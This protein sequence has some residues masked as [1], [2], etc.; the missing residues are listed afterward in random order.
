MSVAASASVAGESGSAVWSM[1]T[2]ELRQRVEPREPGIADHELQQRGVRRD[3][4]AIHLIRHPGIVEEHLVELEQLAAQIAQARAVLFGHQGVRRVRGR[5]GRG[6]RLGRGG[7]KSGEIETLGHHLQRA[8]RVPRPLGA[9]TIPVELEA[10]AVRDRAGRAPR[11]RRGRSPR[12]AECR[13]RAGGGARRRA[14][15][16]RDTGSRSDTARS[17]PGRADRPAG[18]PRCSGRCDG[19]SR[20]RSERP[21]SDPCAASPRTRARPNR[22]PARVRD[23]T[24]SGA[25]G[26]S[27]CGDRWAWPCP[28]DGARAGGQIKRRG[29]SSDRFVAANLHGLRRRDD[30]G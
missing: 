24:P 29:S 17:F 23:R 9:W 6:G 19:G 12:R 4:A 27:R 26:R 3:P 13:R 8:V 10:V 11:S 22:T 21:P 28:H 2:I 30:R 20:R 16:G 1:R 18:F 15:R 25:R 14:R 7:E 5:A